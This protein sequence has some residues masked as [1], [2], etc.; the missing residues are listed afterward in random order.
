MT[1]HRPEISQWPTFSA[2]NQPGLKSQ[3]DESSTISMKE[4]ALYLEAF[5]A[6]AEFQSG[7]AEQGLRNRATGHAATPP[8]PE[9]MIED[10]ES[11]ASGW[12][13][14]SS[15]HSSEF[16]HQH[17]IPEI[18]NLNVTNAQVRYSQQNQEQ[19]HGRSLKEAH[20]VAAE[21][22]RVPKSGTSS[23][24]FSSWF[25]IACA[26]AVLAWMLWAWIFFVQPTLL[27]GLAV[28]RWI[29]SMSIN[30]SLVMRNLGRTYFC[31]APGA[32]YLLDCNHSKTTAVTLSQSATIGMVEAMDPALRDINASAE[33][34]D[35]LSCLS[36]S[37]VAS[38]LPY[39]MVNPVVERTG[40]IS[41][42]LVEY[43]TSREIFVMKVEKNTERLIQKFKSSAS[44]EYQW[45]EWTASLRGAKTSR[46]SAYEDLIEELD[47]WSW[48]LHRLQILTTEVSDYWIE[49]R[50]V[51]SDLIN[52]AKADRDDTK[53]HQG[54]WL[55][56]V[57]VPILPGHFESIAK[58]EMLSAS[59]ERLGGITSNM[60]T[61]H[62]RYEEAAVAMNMA[63][64]TYERRKVRISKKWQEGQ[65][66]WTD[67]ITDL[68]TT[69]ERARVAKVLME[70]LRNHEKYRQ[71]GAGRG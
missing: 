21:I 35:L 7:V 12:N 3:E 34:V 45:S 55:A 37:F 48:E 9:T 47:E 23:I 62:C 10:T 18:D 51:I 63:R 66:A 14:Y 17:A 36:W 11:D 25:L 29:S 27:F 53:A 54:I 8:K 13:V 52:G 28:A 68:R 38:D 46:E 57:K 1:S 4:Q 59:I 31:H 69:M 16:D 33:V 2:T 67:T 30:T 50:L 58:I 44:Q 39:D 40:K 22:S 49:T 42:M 5:R 6:G 15:I 43:H 32:S 64:S 20:F 41:A 65:I 19:E 71:I 70:D 26:I 56:K 60:A 61:M 24:S